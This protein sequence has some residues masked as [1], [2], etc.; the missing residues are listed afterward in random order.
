M[1]RLVGIDASRYTAEHRTGTENY[2]YHLINAL[3]SSDHDHFDFRLYLNANESNAHAL[4]TDEELRSIPFPRLWTH[5]RLS[6][7]MMTRRPDLLFVPSH[8]IPLAHPRSVV[9][10]HDLGYLHEPAAHPAG[11]RLMLDW[12]TRWNA[13]VAARI[14]AISSVTK[15]DL[16]S[17]YG[18]D[19]HKVAVIS[20]GV[21]DQFSPQP[22]E[23][24]AR[25]RDRLGLPERF[26]LAVGTIQPRKNLG[27]LARAVRRLRD[28]GET[29]S[30][31]TAGKSGW[32]AD[33]VESEIREALPSAAWMHLGYVPDEEL[34]ALY[35]A[36]DVVALISR[37]EGFGLPV[38]EAMAS[39]A[40]VVISD[41]GSLPEVAGDAALVSHP[42][43]PEL[44]A[45][46][47]RRPLVDASL[48]DELI[49]RGIAR[50]SAFTWE[51]AAKETI[52]VFRETLQMHMPE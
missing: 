5:A 26:V 37:F 2:S 39:G 30:L 20:H 52:A 17:R 40:P 48:R 1:R 12:T 41:R 13:R 33:Q 21:S 49:K 34:P 36:A 11:Q 27:N 6:A 16:V 22:R 9:T 46:Q 43:D 42:E 47:I 25:L 18:V 15:N 3:A 45:G 14:I 8:V 19:E 4:L 44:I 51:R 28:E 24:I 10:V 35:S 29:I 7:E 50:A 38:L 32:M 31:V 23:A